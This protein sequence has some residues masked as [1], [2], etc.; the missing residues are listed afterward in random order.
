MP[1]Y[2]KLSE[3][4]ID[5]CDEIKILNWRENLYHCHNTDDFF[6]NSTMSDIIDK[7]F[8]FRNYHKSY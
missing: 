7:H 2:S 8:P 3:I 1:D 6:I 5:L 4:A